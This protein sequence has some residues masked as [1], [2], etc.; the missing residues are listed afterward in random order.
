VKRRR[1]TAKEQDRQLRLL[2]Q[3]LGALV[4]RAVGARIELN[5]EELDRALDRQILLQFSPEGLVIQGEANRVEV[6]RSRL[7][8]P[9]GEDL[10]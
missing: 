10:N 5:A 4:L 8:G 1:S 3:I 9:R 6:P 7:I 2:Q